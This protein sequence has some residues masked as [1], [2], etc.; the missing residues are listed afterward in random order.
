MT[1]LPTLRVSAVRHPGGW[2]AVAHDADGHRVVDCGLH[3]HR[4]MTAAL[5]CAGKAARQ[6]LVDRHVEESPR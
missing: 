3:R 4:T 6:W 2:A 5:L 1:E